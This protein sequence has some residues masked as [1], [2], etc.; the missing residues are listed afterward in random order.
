[1]GPLFNSLG[2]N[3]SISFCVF[4][5]TR[6][7]I[8]SQ[9]SREKLQALLTKK[10][11]GNA[12]LFAKGR[13][14]IEF[15]L[16]R[17]G[18]GKGDG[19]ITQAFTCWAVED[20]IRRSGATPIFADTENGTMNL[21]VKTATNAIKDKKNVKALIVQH[22]LGTP[23]K[24]KEIS[25]FCKKQ[26]I[27]LIED[28]AQGY[29]A[30]DDEEKEVGTDADAVVL[31]FGRDKIID[32]VSGGAAVI[33]IKNNQSK[34]KLDDFKDELP[35]IFVIR[36]LLSPIMTWVIRDTYLL[37]FGKALHFFMR[38]V[39]FLT[40]PI[41]NDVNAISNLNPQFAE[42]ALYSLNR[43]HDDLSH[44][45]KIALC[46]QQHLPTSVQLNNYDVERS[47]NLR[48]PIF[49]VD[50]SKV[51]DRLS[52]NNIYLADRWYRSPVDRGNLP[53]KSSYVNGSCP[54]AERL[55]KTII[56][57]PTHRQITLAQA[58]R[59]VRAVKLCLN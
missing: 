27:Y 55:S 5:F 12:F 21:S 46:Y 24:M 31:S 45:K 17:L 59:I 13:D 57:L 16:R 9:K 36:D 34:M 32:A 15:S 20:G 30:V 18:I 48:F 54:N 6:L 11:A 50:P 3:Y 38:N 25:S 29:G 35:I 44:R 22:T 43:S 10:F 4:A 41:G 58:K 2:S 7:F 40:N 39:G 42:L 47:S 52:Q 51:I 1:M 14:A 19:V 56:N 28:L 33:R 53:L 23:A 49:V 8:H 37:Y 26:R